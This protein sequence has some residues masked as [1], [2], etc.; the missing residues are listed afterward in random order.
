VGGRFA[1]LASKSEAA[2]IDKGI[3]FDGDTS[4]PVKAGAV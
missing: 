1:K 2:P 3:M 4:R